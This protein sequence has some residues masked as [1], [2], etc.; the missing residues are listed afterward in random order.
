MPTKVL[1]VGADPALGE[2]LEEW[3]AGEDCCAVHERPE[4]VL[5]DLPFPRERGAEALRRA[6]EAHPDAPVVAMPK[7]LTRDAFIAALHRAMDDVR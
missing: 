4:V 3:L 7:P 1:V 5:V 2:L 6:A